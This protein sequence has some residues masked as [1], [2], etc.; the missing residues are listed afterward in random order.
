MIDAPQSFD[1]EDP[2]NRPDHQVQNW[3]KGVVWRDMHFR[4]HTLKQIA[5]KEKVG[6][7]YVARLID[8]SFLAP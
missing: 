1:R 7:S 2:F 8:Q 4:G 5:E 3:V 6:L